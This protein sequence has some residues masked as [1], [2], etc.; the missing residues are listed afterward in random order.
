MA[1]AEEMLIWMDLHRD[2]FDQKHCYQKKK[3][4]GV[5]FMLG[6]FLGPFGYLYISWRYFSLALCSC[7]IFA[8]VA[9]NIGIKP[10]D[11]MFYYVYPL[12]FAFNAYHICVMINSEINEELDIAM[13]SFTYA[14]MPISQLFTGLVVITVLILGIMTSVSVINEGLITKGLIR[15]LVLTPLF[16][17]VFYIAAKFIGALIIGLF[18]RRI[19]KLSN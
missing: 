15:L 7:F 11:W 19:E 5:G 18:R 13:N 1:F 3:N 16:S 4:L 8:L 12:L 2:Q 9:I 6:L 10:L 17:F 14:M